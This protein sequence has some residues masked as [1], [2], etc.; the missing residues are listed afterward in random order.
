MNDLIKRLCDEDGISGNE[1]PIRERILIEV[2]SAPDDI[3]T[4]PLGNLIMEKGRN[5]LG[6]CTKIMLAAHMDEV[7][8]RVRFI[9]KEGYIYFAKVGGITDHGLPNQKVIIGS[10]R[11]SGVIGSK[12]PHKMDGDELKKL[13]KGKDLFIDI[14]VTSK[15]EAEKLVKIGDPIIFD[16][17]SY[18]NGKFITGKAM[19]NRVGC[20]IL[21]EALWA[22]ETK[23][24]KTA[25]KVYG[26]AT[27]QEEVGL[28]GAR[29]AAYKISPDVAIALDTTIAG[30]HPGIEEKESTAKLGEGPVITIS[31]GGVISGK[32]LN[33][34]LIRIAE[35]EEIP[36]QVEVGSGGTTDAWAIQLNQEGVLVTTISVPAR[37]IHTAA[38]V[39]HEDDMKNALKLLLKFIEEYE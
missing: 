26:V 14:G 1:D 19:D 4:D 21:I 17:Q 35:Q 29:T 6:L 15:E 24:A 27:V 3:E 9:D 34:E 2:G 38:S 12:P 10:N 16:T 8:F 23:K 18:Q 31:D 39:I 36:Y 20:A 5:P 22:L 30:D 37:Y 32:S 25:H 7:G 11:V 13:I 28:K 33:D